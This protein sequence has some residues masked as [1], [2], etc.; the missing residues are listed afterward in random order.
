MNV[1]SGHEALRTMLNPKRVAV[2]GVSR[3]GFGFGRGILLSLMAMKFDGELFPVN[4]RGGEIAGMTIYETVD[5]IPCP[6]DFAVIAVPASQVPQA[7]EE[8]RLKGAAG[9]EILS[10]GF[11]ETGTDEGRILGDRLREVV[12]RG[13]RVLGPNCFGV[14]SPSCGL[15]MLPGPDLS[16][17]PGNVAFVSQSGG[18]S[19]DL[20]HM[21]KW[22]GIRFSAVVSFG[23]GID[24][25]ETELLEYFRDDPATG[26]IG[27][28]MEGVE[29]GGDFFR[30][31]RGASE[32]KPV[33]IC[34]GGLSEAG[35]RA[36]AS[37]T[38]SMGGSRVIWESMFRQCNIIQAKNIGELSDALLALTMLPRRSYRG[39]AI[40]G[41]GGALG[42]AAADAAEA[43]GMVIPPLEEGIRDAIDPLLPRPGS[44]S[45]NPIDIANP[46]VSPDN[47]RRIMIE[48]SRDERIDIHVIIQLL[49][50][51][52]ALAA[53]LGRD[54]VKGLV[55]F[56]E[57]ADAVS[58]AVSATGKPAVLVIPN[59]KRGAEALD[60]EEAMRETRREFLARGIPVFDELEE[61]LFAVSCVSLW[62]GRRMR[63]GGDSVPTP[64]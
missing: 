33:V 20:A 32:K 59:F 9:A 3:E 54:S 51:Y 8:C 29:R 42:V 15:T 19:I 24:V 43:L 27:M 63:R 41:G 31:L 39:A 61:A 30:T 17:E 5:A 4:P 58:G 48:A 44:S 35:G 36:V 50:H 11:D 40:I 57:L 52:G 2:I 64:R 13:I 60:I 62:C 25:R 21:G 55:P 10:S 7:L 22:K 56:R 34:K 53:T 12:G 47:I 38:A 18:M 16:R 1:R 23:N 26:V 37:H 46:Y 28:Y 6:I 49:Y 14:Y 45:R